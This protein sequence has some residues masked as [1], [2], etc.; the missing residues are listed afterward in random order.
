MSIMDLKQQMKE[1]L[2]NYMDSATAQAYMIN[3]LDPALATWEGKL[4]TKRLMPRLRLY[5]PEDFYLNI[6][7]SYNGMEI[8]MSKGNKSL[9]LRLTESRTN[10]VLRMEYVRKYNKHWYD[11]KETYD[12]YAG[13]LAH[14]DEWFEEYIKIRKGVI[15]LKADMNKY[16]CEYLLDFNLHYITE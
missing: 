5:I 16:G 9:T 1:K 2:K 7:K 11:A 3:L 8:R 10:K 4:V 12:R 13:A 6:V 14:I 15:D